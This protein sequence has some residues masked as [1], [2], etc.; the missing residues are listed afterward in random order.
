LP[1]EAGEDAGAA[2]ALAGYAL[3]VAEQAAA[4]LQTGVLAAR[5]MTLACADRLS[6]R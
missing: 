1:A 2:L 5:A 4:A 6:D 3:E